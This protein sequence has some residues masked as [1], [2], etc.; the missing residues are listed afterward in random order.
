MNDGDNVG[1]VGMGGYFDDEG[2]E[3]GLI[4]DFGFLRDVKSSS[5]VR[6][7]SLM[8]FWWV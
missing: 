4:L 2:D 1:I 5:V 7:L 8:S 3:G 6:D